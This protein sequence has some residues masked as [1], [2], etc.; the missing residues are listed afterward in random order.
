MKPYRILGACSG[1]SALLTQYCLTTAHA[2]LLPGSITYFGFFTIWGNLLVALAFTAPLLPAATRPTFFLRPGVRAAIGVYI[3]VIAVVYYF[4]LRKL[5]HLTGLDWYVNLQL[6]DI[7]PPLYV[8]DWAFFVPKGQLRF[9]QIPYWLICPLVY[10]GYVLL[11]GAL[12]SYYP[13]PF[14]NAATLGYPRV[15]LNIA[16]LALLFAGTGAGFI[17]AGRYLPNP[18]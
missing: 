16:G 7:N 11:H 12:S 1:W 9:R 2:G 8:L 6:H 13:Y 4:L 17:A 15:S 10:A 3:L 18:A 14:L 5:Y